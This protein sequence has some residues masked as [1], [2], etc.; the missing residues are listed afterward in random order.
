MQPLGLGDQLAGLRPHA[1]VGVV[2]RR[3]RC[4][5]PTRLARSLAVP[6][7]ARRRSPATA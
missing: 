7:H 4:A 6:E 1:L 3:H 2:S 5:P